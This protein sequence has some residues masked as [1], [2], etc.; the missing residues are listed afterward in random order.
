MDDEDDILLILGD[1]NA[2]NGTDMD[3][4]EACV[5]SHGSGTVNHNST[6]FLD[7]TRCHGL[8]IAG[9]WFQHPQPHFWTK[10]SNAGGV[11]KEID[12][13][14]VDSHSRLLWNCRV[15]GS[16]HFLNTDHVLV[17]AILNLKLKSKR[18]VPAQPRLDVGTLK[19]ERVAEEFVNGLSEGLWDLGVSV[20]P[21]ELWSAFKMTILD[22]ASRYLGTHHQA[23]RIF[24][25]EETLDTIDKC[26]RAKLDGRAEMFREL[27]R[28][29]VRLLRADKETYV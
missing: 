14:L 26:R 20:D 21:E 7:F 5:G 24:V 19:D 3:G 27:R 13:V 4:C 28:K 15:Y 16:A 2:L 29:T 18:M 8:R 23:K 12:H 11:A 22:V 1:L 17:A 25:S 9:S 10:Y 6:R